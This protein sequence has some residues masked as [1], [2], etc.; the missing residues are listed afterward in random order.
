M[1]E[2]YINQILHIV[3]QYFFITLVSAA[4][5]LIINAFFGY[6]IFKFAIIVESAI[7]LGFI[8]YTFI[9]PWMFQN[10]PDGVD[11]SAILGIV[12]AIIGALLAK[13]FIKIMLFVNGAG[14]GFAIGLISSYLLS[15]SNEFFAKE[16]VPY[17]FGA[18]AALILGVLFIFFFKPVY[19]IVSSV[20][21]LAAA[22]FI[23]SYLI[24]P[25]IYVIFSVIMTAIGLVFGIVAA[26]YQF[27]QNSKYYF[28]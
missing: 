1:N 24:C 3:S 7:G 21:G 12:F 18:I 14:L 2:E 10:P 4:I 26:V 15:A 6:K 5:L 16:W 13:F 25:E 23:I 9:G 8:A 27:K 17:V 19:I 20:F 11:L 28:Y 22:G